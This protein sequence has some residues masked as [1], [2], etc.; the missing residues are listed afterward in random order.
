MEACGDFYVFS[1]FLDLTLAAAEEH[2]DSSDLLTSYLY[3]CG[4]C[5]PLLVE[6]RTTTG[7]MMNCSLFN[8]QNERLTDL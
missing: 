4:L 6:R 2:P 3:N 1:L 5:Y 8:K 7:Q